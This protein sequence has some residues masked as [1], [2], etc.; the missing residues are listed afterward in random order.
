M[1]N[2]LIVNM[3]LASVNVVLQLTSQN[4]SAATGW[5]VALMWQVVYFLKLKSEE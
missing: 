3:V 1:K 4:W 5:G 2:L